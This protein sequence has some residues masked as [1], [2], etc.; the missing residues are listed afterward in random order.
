MLR[1][2]R[3]KSDKISSL[4]GKDIT[5]EGL[6]ITEGSLRI[7]GTFRGEIEAKGDVVVGETGKIQGNLVVNNL[8]V[9]GEVIGNIRAFGRLEITRTGRLEGDLET[10]TLVIAEGA[11][12]RGRCLMGSP[13][14]E[15][16]AQ[17]TETTR[18][19]EQK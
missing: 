18:E 7:E 8:L 6:I 11:Q 3:I 16:A 14:H 9:A 4:I 12:Y 5:I 1:K 19:V 17:E 15:T 10:Q 13:G 2:R